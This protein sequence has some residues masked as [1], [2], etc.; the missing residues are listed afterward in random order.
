MAEFP[1]S[2]LGLA[3]VV[4]AGLSLLAL[5]FLVV[6]PPYAAPPPTTP[7]M[8]PAT[9]SG[10]SQTSEPLTYVAIAYLIPVGLMFSSVVPML[11][12]NPE[13]RLYAGFLAV[14]AGAAFFVLSVALLGTDM[15]SIL[16]NSP[17]SSAAALTAVGGGAATSYSYTQG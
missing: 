3:L 1:W 2:A 17:D 4:I 11:S 6:Y 5:F 16:L 13:D 14:A 15:V 9:A 12:R 10:S 7:G 8:L